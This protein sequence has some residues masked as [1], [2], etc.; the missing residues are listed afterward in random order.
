MARILHNYIYPG[1]QDIHHI[2]GGS[3]SNKKSKDYIGNIRKKY[4]KII[5]I[6][7]SYFNIHIIIFYIWIMFILRS[8]VIKLAFNLFKQL[9]KYYYKRL[10]FLNSLIA[11]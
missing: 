1:L 4:D 10:R 2:W 7:S 6:L 3:T 5:N 11:F 9:D 8:I